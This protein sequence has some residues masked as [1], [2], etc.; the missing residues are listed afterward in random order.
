METDNKSM[1][2]SAETCLAPQYYRSE[3]LHSCY[4]YL[5]SGM[6]IA[7]T[8]GTSYDDCPIMMLNL[9]VILQQ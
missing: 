6:S 2:N 3:T 7:C 5:R 1:T 4:A 8:L 9:S